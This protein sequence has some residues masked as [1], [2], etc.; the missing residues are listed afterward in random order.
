MK[1]YGEYANCFKSDWMVSH[2]KLEIFAEEKR[3]DLIAEAIMEVAH[4]GMEGDGIIAVLPVLK[5]Y[6]IRTKKEVLPE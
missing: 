6:R 4:S 3:A 2:S 1:G 5:L